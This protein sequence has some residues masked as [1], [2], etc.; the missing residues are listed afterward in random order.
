MKRL[1]F[2]VL[3]LA[4]LVLEAMPFSAVM[5]FA[6]Q[7]DDG[8]IEYIRRPTSYFSLPPFGYADFGPLLTALLSCLLLTLTV[9]LCVRPGT[10]IYKAVLTVNALAVITSLL[11]LFLGTAFYSFAGA[12]ISVALTAQLLYLLYSK[13]KETP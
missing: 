8:A 11:P 1:R 5:L 13:R 6:V 3:P 2:L 9:W 7:G 4:A 10:G 12:V